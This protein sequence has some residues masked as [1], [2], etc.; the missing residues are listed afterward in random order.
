MSAASVPATEL[1]SQFVHQAKFADLPP[2]VVDRTLIHILDVLGCVAVGTKLPW[3]DQ[4]RRY[5]LEA[6]RT[7]ASTVVGGSPLVAEWAAFANATAAH[8]F[9]LDDYHSGALSHPGCVVIPTVLA[10]AEE[11]GS[12]GPDIVLACALGLETIVRIGLATS[13]SMVVDRGIH[14]TCVQGVFGAAVAAGKLLGLDTKALI[15]ALG[16]AGSHASGTREYAHSGGEVKRLHAGLGAMGG[17]R[18]AVLTKRGLQGPTR[19][20]EGARGVIQA[21]AD[22]HDVGEIVRDLGHEWRFLGCGIKPYASCGVIHAPTDALV[23]LVRENG[24]TVDAID[25]IVVGVDRLSM[26]HVGSLPLQPADMNGAQFNLPYSLGMALTVGGNAFSHYWRLQES[27]F[28]NDAVV[29][30]ARKVRMVIDEEVNH[31]FPET[32]MSRVRVKRCDGRW[33]EKTARPRGSKDRP[34]SL[35]EVQEKFRD[36]VGETAW[37]AQAPAIEKA[38]QAL[39]TGA[40]ASDLMKLLATNAGGKTQDRSTKLRIGAAF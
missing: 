35:T 22:K 14:E 34:L 8:G 23:E 13:P 7:G 33:F 24:L 29:A 39:R 2:Q 27:N 32:L 15:S 10:I 4:V 12:S 36:L 28:R 1:L 5:A 38:V 20:L 40:R 6:G 30:A 9:E 37:T 26:E 31:A 18:G 11:A 16:I 21:F 19:I 25:E 17:I 3:I